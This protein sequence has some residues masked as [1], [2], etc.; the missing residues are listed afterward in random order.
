MITR[1]GLFY[2][3]TQVVYV[4]NMLCYTLLYMSATKK[5]KRGEVKSIGEIIK[6]K[7]SK[8][9][10]REVR[11]EKEESTNEE[12][13]PIPKQKKDKKKGLTAV[14]IRRRAVLENI[15]SNSKKM[16]MYDAMI[17]QGYSHSY[18]RSSTQLTETKDFQKL[19]E[20]YLPDNLLATTHGDL[21]TASKL[22][23]ML[24]NADI[25][26]EEIYELLASKGII[27]KKII[28]G[29]QGTHVWFF[30]PDNKIRKEAT[31]LG[32]K[33]KGKMA[34]EKFEVAGGLSA[35]SD[36]EL[37]AIIKKQTDKL[38]KKD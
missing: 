27:P 12:G 21:M 33:V 22:E 23:Y 35:V 29:I 1:I 19:M 10:A 32:Y 17:A 18:A 25:K 5:T 6:E 20:K 36:A 7:P 15:L 4:L 9:P 16:S 26:D 28:H 13:T 34:P 24:F 38:R 14:S 11:R 37:A 8:I 30:S 3:Y 31:E 2:I